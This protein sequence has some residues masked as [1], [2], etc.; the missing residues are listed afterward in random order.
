KINHYKK[1]YLSFRNDTNSNFLT[2]QLVF[3]DLDE[4][5]K[6]LFDYF[7]DTDDDELEAL[8]ANTIECSSIEEALK[9][10]NDNPKE[11]I[12]FVVPLNNTIDDLKHSEDNTVISKSRLSELSKLI[13]Q[14][15]GILPTPASGSI[16]TSYQ[17][18]L[19]RVNTLKHLV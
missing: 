16:E 17:E 1:K 6:E 4:S 12:R 3:S 5:F 10:Y 7:K 14:L 8:E 18:A 13:V 19:S 9:L 2:L 11:N 15:E